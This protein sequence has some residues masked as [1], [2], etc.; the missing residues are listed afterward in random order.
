MA[1]DYRISYRA[2]VKARICTRNGCGDPA[3]PG[4]VLCERHR[5]EALDYYYRVVVPRKAANNTLR[6]EQNVSTG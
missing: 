2:R 5:R 6:C 4:V 1:Y 3:A